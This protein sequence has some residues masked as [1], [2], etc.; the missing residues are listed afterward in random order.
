MEIMER[1]NMK[2]IKLPAEFI[3]IGEE[4]RDFEFKFIAESAYGYIYQVIAYD[5]LWYEIF[6]KKTVRICIDYKNKIYSEDTIKEIYPKA[7]HFGIWA[8]TTNSKEKAMEYLNNI[9]ASKKEAK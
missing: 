4:I 5:D 3:G 7:K 9:K 8:W 2:V 1:C 6:R